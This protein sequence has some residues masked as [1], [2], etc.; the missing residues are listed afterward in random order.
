MLSIIEA[1][2]RLPGGRPINSAPV[3]Q[4]PVAGMRRTNNP[5]IPGIPS[6]KQM[7]GIPVG[8]NKLPPMPDTAKRMITGNAGPGSAIT[9]PAQ[10]NRS[11][12]ARKRMMG[13]GPR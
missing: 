8:K 9:T 13:G 10:V 12:L 4:R 7:L 1:M 3:P 5:M 6:K 11:P 2:Q